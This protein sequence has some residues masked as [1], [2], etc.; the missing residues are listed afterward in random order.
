MKV[1]LVV[2]YFLPHIG[3]MEAV[4]EKQAK[5][6]VARGHDVTVLTCRP[7]K[8]LPAV[9]LRDGY[10]IKRLPSLNF[11]EKKFGV[12]YPIISVHHVLGLI[13]DVRSYDI[14]HI[15]DVFYMSSHLV[16]LSCMLQKKAYFLTQHVAMVDYPSALI[17]AVQRIMYGTFGRLLFSQATKIVCYN[18]IVKSFLLKKGVSESKIFMQYN[19]IDCSYFSPT[20][21][22]EKQILRK[23]YNLPLDRPVVLF[24]GRLVPKKGYELVYKAQGSD[25]FTLLVGE[26]KPPSYMKSTNDA[27]LF[28]PASSSQ[29]RDLYRA[30]DLFV[31]PAIGEIFTLVMQEAMASGLPVLIADDPGYASYTFSNKYIRLVNRTDKDVRRAVHE[32]MN[33]ST[34][35]SKMSEYSRKFAVEN[36]DWE[37]NY[38]N[39]YALYNVGNHKNARTSNA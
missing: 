9:E 25:Y 5:S 8:G 1:L 26:G 35:R 23:K 33:D 10:T 37:H 34:M 28:G 14:V 3:G 30:C 15:H 16:A 19:G 7:E 18:H 32:I 6:L 13:R 12:T 20:N 22:K 17:L 27:R 11:I 24:A 29:L 2:H 4:V 21:N 38:E 39:E 31:F 36:F